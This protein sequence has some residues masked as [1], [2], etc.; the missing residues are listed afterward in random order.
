MCGVVAECE[1]IADC[2]ADGRLLEVYS[3]LGT[4]HHKKCCCIV[5]LWSI[6]DVLLDD[7]E[8][9]WQQTPLSQF[10][11]RYSR[12]AHLITHVLYQ[13]QLASAAL[14]NV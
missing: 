10:I 14:L 8:F 2:C 9:F 7:V 12:G 1:E 3:P 5:A 6:R 11:N 4:Y 13:N